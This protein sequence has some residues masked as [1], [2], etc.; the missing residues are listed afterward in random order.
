M[1]DLGGIDLEQQASS[2]NYLD[3][4]RK[5]AD[6]RSST[7]RVDNFSACSLQKYVL[8]RDQLLLDFEYVIEHAGSSKSY[9]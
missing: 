2:A 6:I 1:E 8:T 3:A 4:A 9:F 5:L 7:D